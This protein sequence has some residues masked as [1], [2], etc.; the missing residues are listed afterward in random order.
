L[1]TNGN[2]LHGE[3]KMGKRYSIAKESAFSDCW[4]TPGIY[5]GVFERLGQFVSDFFLHL[6]TRL[7]REKAFAYTKGLL[8]NLEKKNT[9]SIAYC[10]GY[11]RQPLQMFI[12][13]V[14][15]NDDIILDDLADQVALEIGQDDGILVI[16]PTSFPK[17]GLKRVGVGITMLRCPCWVNGF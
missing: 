3:Q 11:D 14:E 9:E 10:H 16:D 12:G 6:P 4:V 1:T 8:S 5:E 17:K 15:W 2:F 7:Q 13:Q